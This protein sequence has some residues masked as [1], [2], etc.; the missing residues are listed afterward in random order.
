MQIPATVLAAGATIRNVS[1][2]I[3]LALRAQAAI[4]NW[5][6]ITYSLS[7]RTRFG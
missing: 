6:Q 1:S 7:D 5:A 3:K 4:K 2:A